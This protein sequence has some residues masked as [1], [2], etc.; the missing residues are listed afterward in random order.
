MPSTTAGSGSGGLGG[1][2]DA[3][4]LAARAGSGHVR[5]VARCISLIENG[6]PEAASILEALDRAPGRALVVGL[7]G[8]PGAGK[9]TLLPA[10]AQRL[11]ARGLRPAILA[12]DPSSP[13]S[14]GAILGDRFRD[15]ASPESGVFFRSVASRGSL[16][17]LSD[18]LDDVVTLLD[19]ARFDVVLIETVGTG[20]SEIAVTELA[21][22]TFAVTAPGLG[23]EI[24]AMKAGILE[25]ADA[26]V[27]NKADAD[28][29]GAEVTAATLRDALLLSRRFHDLKE[30]ANRATT[31]SAARWLPPVRAVSALLGDGLDELTE[32]IVAHRAFLDGSGGHEA[33]LSRRREARLDSALRHALL[34]RASL[35]HGAAL[36]SLRADILAGRR[37]PS[38]GAQAFA[39]EAIAA[40][41]A[42]P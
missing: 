23:D 24:Q 19:A 8:I 10:L 31:G 40:G 28:P 2:A 21:H 16:G 6:R 27:V 9:S 38:A 29:A 22:T 18:T 34:D 41:D 11:M 39:R 26:V 5:S 35:A 12:V 32:I 42:Q 7:T 20:Q 13:L 15:A 30:G 33:W 1:A 3:L 17:G 14:G 37:H 36:A 25:V 4:A